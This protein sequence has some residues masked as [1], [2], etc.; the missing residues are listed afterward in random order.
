M[1]RTKK[2]DT[3]RTK[4][5]NQK[6]EEQM[7][8]VDDVLHSATSRPVKKKI[9][10]QLKTKFKSKKQKTFFD[11]IMDKD[12]RIIFAK[13]SPGSGKTFIS[14]MAGLKMIKDPSELNINKILLS[15]VI[16]PVGRDIG[17]LKGDLHDKTSPYFESFWS[18][19]EKIV[20]NET[21][22]GLR[23]QKIVEETIVN[24]VRGATFGSYDHNGNPIGTLAILDE[25]QNT[26]VHEMKTFISRMGENTKLVIL[27]DAE[28]I[29]IKLPRGEKN[30]L[31][32]AF[33]RFSGLNGIEFVE[34]TEDDIV[35]DPFLI[36][37]MKRYKIDL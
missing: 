30:G 11:K 4:K 14:L 35:R 7:A 3:V 13:G 6:I 20:G 25:A 12:N 22:K 32:D 17:H 9:D 18:N 15:K 26:T 23:E 31:D 24:F 1:A 5:Y 27:G 19:I 34:F 36:D 10:I 2:A 8:I 29:D 16:V 33:E 21:S 37:V 28:Q